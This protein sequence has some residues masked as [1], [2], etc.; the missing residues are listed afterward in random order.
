MKTWSNRLHRNNNNKTLATWYAVKNRGISRWA[1]HIPLIRMAVPNAIKLYRLDVIW[2]GGVNVN[3]LKQSC[4]S[5]SQNRATASL[6]DRRRVVKSF[7]C[8]SFFNFVSLSV[9]L[10]HAP[11]Y[12]EY[13][14]P[15]V[16]RHF[17]VHCSLCSLFCTCMWWFSFRLSC[18]N[19]VGSGKIVA[20]HSS[21]AGGQSDYRHDALLQAL[22]SEVCRSIHC[23]SAM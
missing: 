18:S 14:R 10:R 23:P 20:G 1:L 22:R 8:L 6:A 13:K 7:R 21:V 15:H 11:S 2:H 19:N 12:Q 16:Q 5:V 9:R 3:Q 17:A 4:W